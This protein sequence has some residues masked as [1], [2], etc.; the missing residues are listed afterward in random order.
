MGFLICLLLI[1]LITMAQKASRKVNY[2]T[3]EAGAIT[4]KD[5]KGVARIKLMPA[6]IE[7]YDAAS[8]FAGAVR[9]DVT[10]LNEVK[11]AQYSVFDT[12]GKD[13]ILL[14]IHGERPSIQMINEEGRVRTAVG[15]EAIV[16]FGN[17]NDEYNSIIA[18]RVSIRDASSA[19][20]TLGVTET[21]NTSSGKQNKTSAATLTLFGKDGKIIWRAP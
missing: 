14:A 11:A 7:F 17:T 19:T 13:R 18:D 9:E 12:N 3:I 8:K 20:A 2:R 4:L 15:Q 21:L 10:I 6:G 16:L 5:S 1:P